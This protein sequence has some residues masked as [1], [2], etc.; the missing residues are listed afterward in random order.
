MSLQNEKNGPFVQHDSLEIESD[1]P[2][3]IPISPLKLNLNQ[4]TQSLILPTPKTSTKSSVKQVKKKEIQIEKKNTRKRKTKSNP[5]TE[6]TVGVSMITRNGKQKQ[7]EIQNENHHE[8]Q[9]QEKDKVVPWNQGKLITLQTKVNN[10]SKSNLQES[11][12]SKKPD[13]I[14]TPSSRIQK[15]VNEKQIHT[16][17]SPKDKKVNESIPDANQ[18]IRSN[19]L[20]QS[21][22]YVPPTFEKDSDPIMSSDVPDSQV[23]ESHF[24]ENDQEIQIQQQQFESDLSSDSIAPIV[25]KYTSKTSGS[26]I[27]KNHSVKQKIHDFIQQLK[28][29]SSPNNELGFELDQDT[30]QEFTL[31]PH[32]VSKEDEEENEEHDKDDEDDEE[33]PVFQIKSHPLRQQKDQHSLLI[34]KKS[35]KME[36]N[37]QKT[38]SLEKS[39]LDLKRKSIQ[40]QDDESTMIPSYSHYQNQS[41]NSSKGKN[42]GKKESKKV[43]QNRKFL[44]LK[45]YLME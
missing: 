3:E 9:I 22:L 7:K 29:E 28:S 24:Q 34:Y 25:S 18:I 21:P 26:A 35:K 10:F 2:N 23:F 13:Q 17:N 43:K 12:E 45:H 8:I 31:F 40:L 5:V 39:R 32:N 20:F 19:R 1:N 15:N 30:D 37:N 4:D 11:F 6:T 41:K 16:F 42:Q 44:F 33:E 14:P 27:G 38:L 36:L